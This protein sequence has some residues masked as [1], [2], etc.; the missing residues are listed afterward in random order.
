MV[1]RL[2]LHVSNFGFHRYNSLIYTGC[3]KQEVL[4][5]IFNFRLK[6]SID[7]LEVRI[8]DTVILKV[9]QLFSEEINLKLFSLLI[10]KLFKENIN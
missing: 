1:Y 6:I 2:Y 7:N 9:Y 5:R 8:N 4:L 10:F 3:S